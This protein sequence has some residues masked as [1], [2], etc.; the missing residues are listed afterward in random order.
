LPF[1]HAASLL[2]VVGRASILNKGMPVG[3]GRL[4]RRNGA[5]RS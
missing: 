3:Q 2:I 5:R 1:H 4:A